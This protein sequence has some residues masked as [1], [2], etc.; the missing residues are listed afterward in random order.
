MND[1]LAYT[2]LDQRLMSRAVRYF[3]WQARVIAPELG[4][5]VVEV[6]CGTGNF[7]RSL[8]DREAIVA[9]DIE[10]ACIDSL[11]R[12]Y[13]ARSNLFTAVCSPEDPEFATL[14]RFRPDSCVCLNVLEHIE[15]D[16]QALR[17]MA[18]IL[19]PGGVIALLVPAFPALYGPTDRNL[20]HH[21]RYTARAMRDLAE[22]A[23]LT[24]RKLRYFNLAGFFGWW[25]NAR[26]LKLEAQSTRQIELFDRWF[27]PVMSRVEAIVPLPFGQSLIAVLQKS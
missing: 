16:G 21:R 14:Q 24:V 13:P 6:G 8:L 5:R 23:G 19:P 3:E 12:R 9:V 20:A 10:P 22:Q 26:V 15:D 17:S 7:T 27:V 4:Q 18:A 11:K 1:R 2:L 25:L